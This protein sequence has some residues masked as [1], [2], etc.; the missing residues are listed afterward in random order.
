[1][2]HQCDY[3]DLLRSVGLSPTPRRERV[4][5]IIGNHQG[6]LR[7]SEI[8]AVVRKRISIDRVTLYRILDLLVEKRLVQ[9]LSAGDRT[10]RYGLA[11]TS[12]HPDHA[13]FHCVRCGLM[14]CLD[15]GS[16]PLEVNRSAH[17]QSMRIERME[18]RLDGLCQRC[19][20]QE[21]S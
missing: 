1:M 7:A 12:R 2:C 14:E 9:R 18:I 17:L 13:H 20:S 21:E 19:R 5:E 6:V 11:G 15:P 10:F 3:P 8:L 4:L 16:V